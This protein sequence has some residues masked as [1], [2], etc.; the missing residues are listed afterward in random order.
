MTRFLTHGWVDLD[1]DNVW[2]LG[3][4]RLC[5]DNLHFLVAAY[6]VAVA[7]KCLSNIFVPCLS[8]QHC[9]AWLIL[10]F[11]VRTIVDPTIVN[12]DDGNWQVVT[13]DGFHFHAIKAKRAVAFQSND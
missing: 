6:K 11:T 3:F 4:N 12:Y 9:W 7:A 1:V 10:N 5:K 2:P 8:I 13:T